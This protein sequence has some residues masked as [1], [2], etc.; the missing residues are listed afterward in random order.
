MN[1]IYDN[2]YALI[3]KVNNILKMLL[4]Q[5]NNIDDDTTCMLMKD[6]EE[7]SQDDIVYINYDY[8]MSYSIDS[9]NEKDIVK[10]CE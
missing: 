1:N 3:G 8:G 4:T 5:T 7:Y 2:G 9:W 10:G 6:L